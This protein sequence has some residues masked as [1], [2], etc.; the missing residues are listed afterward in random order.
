MA[1]LGE[2]E[3]A[4]EHTLLVVREVSVYKI[5]P[6]VTSGGYK[7]GEWLQ[8]DKIWSGRLR[9]VSC[10]DRCEIR[11]E[12][13]GSGD[14]FAACFVLPGQRESSVETVLD[15]SRYFVLRIEDGRG[16]H[17]FVG[18]GFNERNE[19]FDFNVALSDHEKYVKREHEKETI[20]GEDNE[21]GQIDIHPVVNR[22]LKEGETIRINVKNK[23]STGSGMLSSAGLSGGSNAK[24]KASVLLAPPPGAAGKLRSPLPPPPNDPAAARMNSG[25]NAGIRPPKEPAKRNSDAFSDLS[26]MKQN[27]PSSTESGQTKGTGAGWAAF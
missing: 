10:G 16:K 25:P 23:P 15:S 26:A 13:P 11:L 8:S 6:R 12:D 20:G 19:A 5:P 14:L 3:E 22:R 18:L 27:L 21:D 24:P 2:E 9:V 1:S 17:A 7:C 4:F